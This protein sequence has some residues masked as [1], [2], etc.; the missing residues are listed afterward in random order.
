MSLEA[1]ARSTCQGGTEK[2]AE[3]VLR[4]WGVKHVRAVGQRAERWEKRSMVL[5]AVEELEEEEA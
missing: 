2:R 4:M 3:E 1:A 5:A